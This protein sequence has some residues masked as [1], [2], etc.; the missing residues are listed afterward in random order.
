M[1]IKPIRLDRANKKEQGFKSAGNSAAEMARILAQKQS[2]KIAELEKSFSKK[3]VEGF[4]LTGLLNKR[5]DNWQAVPKNSKALV[6]VYKNP[7]F[8]EK[9]LGFF[10]HHIIK[11]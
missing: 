10:C 2:G 7:N 4:F 8:A 1:F 3:E 5:G 6:K 9:I 11:I